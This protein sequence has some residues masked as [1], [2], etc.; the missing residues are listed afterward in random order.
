MDER[1]LVIQIDGDLVKE[2]EAPLWLLADVF[3]SVQ[4]T[5]NLIAMAET[6]QGINQRARVSEIIKRSCELRR[7]AEHK[8]SYV[9]I[10]KLPSVDSTS[11]YNE[12]I[13]V[14]ARDKFLEFISHVGQNSNIKMLKDIIPDSAYCR[15]VLRSIES[16]CPRPDSKWNL[17]FGTDAAIL[18][19]KINSSSRYTIKQYLSLPDVETRIVTG[20]LVRL[21]LD[22]RTFQ[23]YYKPNQ[24]RLSC[25]YDTEL[26]E[27]IIKNLR[28]KVQV[29]GQVVL[30]EEGEPSKIIEVS[31]IIALDLSPIIVEE[32]S[33]N[34]F[35][36]HFKNP[37][38]V[39]PFFDEDSQQLVAESKELNLISSGGSRDDLIE[40]IRLDIAWLWQEYALADEKDLSP[41]AIRLKN[42]LLSLQAGE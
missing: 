33:S 8:G 39:T 42:Y 30:D 23:I 40:D 28:D 4:D 36:L 22:E 1:Q 34:G 13:A 41:G 38:Q 32:I 25:S 37:L 24:R 31:D 15:R 7:V 10:A 19:A 3:R 26:E 16:I 12:D 29:V 17:A 9:L 18:S 14:T 2:G 5:I 20:E 27:F 6:D 11:I 21:H 35:I